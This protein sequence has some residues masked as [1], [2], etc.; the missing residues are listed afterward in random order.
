MFVPTIEEL[1]DYRETHQCSIYEARKAI[2]NRMVTRAIDRA[3]TVED[4]KR[5]LH[6]LNDRV[7]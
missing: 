3:E 4:L 6:E 2:V 5:I 7:R 1:T